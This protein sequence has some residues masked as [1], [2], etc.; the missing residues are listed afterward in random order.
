MPNGICADF[1]HDQVG[2]DKAGFCRVGPSDLNI[3]VANWLKKE[4][5]KGP[6]IQPDCL[7]CP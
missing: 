7:D 5:P 2:S 1:A 3:L 6:G 4:P